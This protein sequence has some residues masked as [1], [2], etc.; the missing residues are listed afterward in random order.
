MS[1]DSTPCVYQFSWSLG[2]LYLA[3]GLTS[4]GSGDWPSWAT[5]PARQIRQAGNPCSREDVGERKWA[6]A[7]N[8]SPSRHCS[9]APECCFVSMLIVLWVCGYTRRSEDNLHRLV[10]SLS[11]KESGR[12][13]SSHSWR[14]LPAV[15][16]SWSSDWVFDTKCHC[17]AQ[18]GL[19]LEILL[20]FCLV[21][22]CLVVVWLFGQY[23]S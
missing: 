13:N 21:R 19:R 12:L 3:Q 7:R 16:T 18:A 11:T 22:F 15:S 10:L 23:R 2:I 20:A 8:S 4:V 5:C 6:M 17:V 1:P 9:F 14:T